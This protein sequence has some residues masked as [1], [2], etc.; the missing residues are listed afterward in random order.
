MSD[1]N[2]PA[3][4][5]C[6]IKFQD[7]AESMHPDTGVPIPLHWRR[8]KYEVDCRSGNGSECHHPP[9]VTNMY[10][11]KTGYSEISVG[12]G[13]T[14]CTMRH[15]EAGVTVVEN[16]RMVGEGN[17]GGRINRFTT[18]TSY[19]GWTEISEAARSGDSNT[20]ENDGTAEKEAEEANTE[21]TRVQG[22]IQPEDFQ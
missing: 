18:I 16:N 7:D 11:S 19:N 1:P 12:T 8:M 3:D 22:E 10:N 20:L 21:Q 14:R 13:Q 9:D 2:K 15:K 5:S 4:G 17:R 6:T